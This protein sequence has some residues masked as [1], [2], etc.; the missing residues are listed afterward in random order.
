LSLDTFANLIAISLWLYG[1]YLSYNIYGANTEYIGLALM[2]FMLFVIQASEAD[3]ILKGL[4]GYSRFF[5]FCGLL[6]MLAVI[7]NT[8]GQL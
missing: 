4:S 2:G 5:G 7:K 1:E 3:N 6:V 8:T